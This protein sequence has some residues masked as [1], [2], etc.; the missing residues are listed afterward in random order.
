VTAHGA[1]VRSLGI[2]TV[3]YALFL[4]WMPIQALRSAGDVAEA[5]GAIA[6]ADPD[7]RAGLEKAGKTP[8]DVRDAVAADFR[9]RILADVAPDLALDALAVVAGILLVLRR[10]LGAWLLLAFVAWPAAAWAY[11]SIHETF[12]AIRLHGFESYRLPLAVEMVR[13]EALGRTLEWELGAFMTAVR[14]AFTGLALTTLSWWLIAA[15]RARRTE[16]PG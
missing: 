8:G 14:L 10:R 9:R 15:R 1:A 3:A 16:R 11:R 12:F 5:M 6:G 13:F 7:T 2:V 4:A